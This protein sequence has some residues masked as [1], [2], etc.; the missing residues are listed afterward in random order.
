[1]DVYLHSRESD[2]IAV[3]EV[4]STW[5]VEELL[6]RRGDPEG[7]DAWLED[8]ENPLEHTATL[9]SL[10]VEERSHLHIST[11]RMVAVSV[12][13]GG[14]TKSRDFPPAA[15]VASVFAWAAGPQGFGLTPTERAKHTLAVCEGA[16]ELDRPA[17]I[18]SFAGEDCS[19]CLDLAPKERF[20]G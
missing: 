4:E 13:Y 5:T 8:G 1:M 2:E 7:A 9:A 20:E 18:G 16:A 12:R 10:G 6:T 14:D 15:T 19:V 17:H 11:C 3:V